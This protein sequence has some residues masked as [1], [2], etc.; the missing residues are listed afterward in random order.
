MKHN[1][2]FHVWNKRSRNLKVC[3][4][5]GKIQFIVGKPNYSRQEIK[6]GLDYLGKAVKYIIPNLII[7]YIC[8]RGDVTL[9]GREHLLHSSVVHQVGI[10]C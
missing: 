2:W 7:N 1:I 5:C 3:V 10:L 8:S 6:W 4:H 9:C